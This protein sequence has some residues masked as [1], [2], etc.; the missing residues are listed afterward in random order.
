MMYVTL[1]MRRGEANRKSF[2]EMNQDFFARQPRSS[3]GK[4]EDRE[5]KEAKD[6]E[7]H[8]SSPTHGKNRP[9]LSPEERDT[10]EKRTR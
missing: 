5:T 10:G 2:R 1:C 4:K 9:S 3:R 6:E 7:G 8:P